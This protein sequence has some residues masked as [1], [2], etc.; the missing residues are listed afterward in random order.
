MTNCTCCDGI[1]RRDFLRV[2]ALA[3]LGLN[4]PGFLELAAAGA[5]Q[6]RKAKAAIFVY[7]AGGPSHL[8]T[9]DLKPDA[10]DTHRGAFHEIPTNVPGIRICEHLPKLAQCAEH[11]SILRGVSHTLGDHRLGSLYLNTGNRP[12]PS[13][14]YPSYGAVVSKELP[15]RRDLPAFVAIPYTSQTTGFLNVEYGPLSTGQSPKPGVPMQLRGLSLTGGVTLEEIDRRQNLLHKFDT[16]FGSF[17]QDDKLLSGLDR[18]SQRAYDMLRSPHVRA[19]FDLGSESPAIRGRF[20]PHAFSQSCLLA[21]RLVESGVRFVTVSLGG[22]DTHAD[23]F[24]RLSTQLLPPLDDGLSGLFRTLADK[25][26]L[27]STSVLVTGEFGRTPKINGNAG[28]D[29]HPRAMFCLMGGGGMRG[30]QVIGASDKLGMGPADEPIPPD[31]VAASFY[32]S[33]GI[34]H[35]KEY[36]TSSGRPV[37]IVRNG[38]PIGKLFG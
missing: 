27:E 23:N 6:P 32:H 29:H 15:G 3:G 18:F 17:A 24:N 11:Y 34:D 2:G 35:R 14:D 38:A 13:L 20:G 10:P 7:L 30:G 26:L 28:R 19:A 16:A 1:P 36:H 5:V 22:W 8:D 33:L 4:L 21:A 12:L 37:M 31:N 25:G 9:F